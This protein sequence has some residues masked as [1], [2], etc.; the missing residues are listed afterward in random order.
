MVVLPHCLGPTSATTRLRWSA[1]ST[2]S[3]IAERGITPDGTTKNEHRVFVFHKNCFSS[4]YQG[5]A[6]HENVELA[7]PKRAYRDDC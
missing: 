5:E 2:E 7:Q 3:L 4:P 6:A 1:T